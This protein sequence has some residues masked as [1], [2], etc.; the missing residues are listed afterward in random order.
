MVP[1]HGAAVV[2]D[3]R[4]DDSEE[5]ITLIASVFAEYPGCV[6]DVD[7]EEPQLRR[8]ASAFAE[9]GG[10]LWVA[11]SAARL[12]GSVGFTDDGRVAHLKHLYVAAVA[13]RQGLGSRLTR[14]AESAIRARGHRRV[15]L[16]TDTRFTDAH[17]MYERLG[18]IRGPRTRELHDLSH[19]VEYHYRKNL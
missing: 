5:L 14:L 16:W 10:R 7:A 11:E 19:T 18:Y 4:D 1:D 2:R 3:V 12:V 15:E 6:L 17:R 13:R 9:W 8:P